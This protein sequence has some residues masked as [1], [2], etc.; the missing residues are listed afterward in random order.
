VTEAVV[1]MAGYKFVALDDALAIILYV[2]PPLKYFDTVNISLLLV[3]LSVCTRTLPTGSLLQLYV[4]ILLSASKHE[5]TDTVVY[6]VRTSIG[7]TSSTEEPKT[8]I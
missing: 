4:M 3:L 8:L 6:I 5:D 7:D 1:K 2:D